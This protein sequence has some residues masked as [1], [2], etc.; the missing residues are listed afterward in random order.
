MLASRFASSAAE[1]PVRVL[2]VDDSGVSRALMSRWIDESGV[3]IVAA[4][5]GD[6]AS[7]VIAL[8]GSEIDVVVLDV[9]MPGLDGL[10]ALPHLL[11]ARPGVH[12]LMASSLSERGAE[13]TLEALRLGASDA[14]AKPRAGW[15]AR[16]IASFR[17][18]LIRHIVA[19]GAA[20]AAPPPA[21]PVHPRRPAFTYERAGGVIAPPRVVVV[22]ASTGGP[23]ALFRLVAALPGDLP[24]PLLIAQHMPARFTAV[25]ARQLDERSALHV[26]EAQSGMLLRAGV[27]YLG[28]GGRAMTVNGLAA[29]PVLSFPDDS[30]SQCQPSVDRL[31]VSA[32]EIWGSRVLGIVLSG[33]GN[34][35][36]EGARAIVGAGGSVIA[37]DYAT[38]IV[39]GMPG[40]V[41]RAGLAADVLPMGAIAAEIVRLATEGVAES[42]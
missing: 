20:R 28:Q 17:D 27:A 6:G 11:A 15:A 14:I 26:V 4:V 3:A 34:D 13:V 32:V 18:D 33:M 38:A 21:L 40:G 19:L 30:E 16:G 41:A 37:Q 10:S 12:I 5:A 25:L 42:R 31:M 39:W 22:G 2:L 35:G 36:L 29:A 9:E 7:A 24:V 8:Q 23:N 1:R